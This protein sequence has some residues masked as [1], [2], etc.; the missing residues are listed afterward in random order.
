MNCKHNWHFMKKY[1]NEKLVYT[2]K[3]SF[4]GWIPSIEIPEEGKKIFVDFICDKCLKIKTE[5]IKTKGGT[6][7]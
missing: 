3:G 6:R 5:E 4:L 7:R 2:S 1:S